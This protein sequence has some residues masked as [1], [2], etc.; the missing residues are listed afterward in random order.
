[1]Q[2][3]DDF[4]SDR[5][6]FETTLYKGCTLHELMFLAFISFSF[7]I[8]FFVLSFLFLWGKGLIGLAFAIPVGFF[9]M[10]LLAGILGN[11]KQNKP[12]GYYQQRIVLWLEDKGFM[13]SAYVRRSGRWSVRRIQS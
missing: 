2:A 13:Q 4:K 5:L 3:S 8:A 9:V 10:L 12:Q 1:M 11:F 7:A 6:N